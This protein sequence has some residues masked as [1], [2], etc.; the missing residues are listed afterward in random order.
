MKRKLFGTWELRTHE[1]F[2]PLRLIGHRIITASSATIFFTGIVFNILITF[3]SV[4]VCTCM[5]RQSVNK[6][7]LQ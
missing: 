2:V 3:H 1:P 6:I 7:T 4:S 5:R